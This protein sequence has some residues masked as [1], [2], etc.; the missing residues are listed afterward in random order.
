VLS[1]KKIFFTIKVIFFLFLFSFSIL[2]TIDYF[3]GKNDFKSSTVSQFEKQWLSYLKITQPKLAD[4]LSAMIKNNDWLRLDYCLRNAKINKFCGE[5]EIEDDS[6]K[7]I[8]FDYL[9]KYTFSN[10]DRVVDYKNS[11]LFS[12]EDRWLR[13]NQIISYRVFANGRSRIAEFEN[14]SITYGDS[15]SKDRVRILAIS[16]STAAGSGLYD[17]RE[18]WPRELEKALNSYSDKFEVI[19][20]AVEGANYSDFYK[21]VSSE[22]T[23]ELKPDIIIVSVTP[24]DFD[25]YSKGFKIGFDK[26]FNKSGLSYDILSFIKCINNGDSN[27]K[28]INKVPFFSN[29]KRSLI[30]RFCDSSNK[31]ENIIKNPLL[32]D[33]E[34]SGLFENWVN[35][36]DSYDYYKKIIESSPAPI[37]FLNL[38]SALSYGYESNDKEIDRILSSIDDRFI[39]KYNGSDLINNN[40]SNNCIDLPNNSGCFTANPLDKHL[41]LYFMRAFI[42][43]NIDGIYN[44]VKDI[45]AYKRDRNSSNLITEVMPYQIR[46]KIIDNRYEVISYDSR[47]AYDL[48]LPNNEEL[49]QSLCA[50]ENRNY[51]RIN[52]NENI[53]NNKKIKVNLLFSESN[54]LIKNTG[55]NSDG[56]RISGDYI[57]FDKDTPFTFVGSE[58]KNSIVI[59]LDREGCYNELWG[60]GLVKVAIEVLD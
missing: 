8:D 30:F 31:N 42:K 21:Y 26:S 43:K 54:L 35:I 34:S 60:L 47:S 11:S 2:F 19:T 41:N 56:S 17:I 13:E 36:D 16:D 40:K 1:I 10:F 12:F 52:L 25:Y 4:N 29:L 15:L 9:D 44:K 22:S 33:S 38:T 5:G 3:L 28:L 14:P 7:T 51:I 39:N 49:Y 57:A 37:Y 55:F 53:I 50:F 59:A 46:Y 45:K 58:D 27:V 24:A 48:K 23:R 18:S 6:V 32:I 20:K